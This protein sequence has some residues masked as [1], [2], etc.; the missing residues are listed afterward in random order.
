[1]TTNRPSEKPTAET[2]VALS[3]PPGR[4]GIGIVRL[5]GPAALDIAPALVRTDAPLEHGRA[6][7]GVVLDPAA[8]DPAAATGV[9]EAIVTA[10]LSPRSY[11]GENLV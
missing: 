11:T 3:T 10:F 4:S 2:I 9:D 8:Q 7:F 5:S 6:R 1:M